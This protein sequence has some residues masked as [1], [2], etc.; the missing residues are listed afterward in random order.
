MSGPPVLILSCHRSGS[1]L[2]RYVLDT[3][4]EIYSP[5]ELFLGN[6]AADLM[7]FLAGLDGEV[8]HSDRLA[9]PRLQAC[10]V[11]A[12][13]LLGERL[14][15]AARRQGKRLWCEKT[16]DN[17]QHLGLLDALFPDTRY[18]CLYRHA[19]DVARSGS[20]MLERIPSLLPYLYASRGHVTTALLRYWT[21]R[22]EALLRFA[23]A[24]PGRVHRVIYED[25]VSDPSATVGPLF[26]FL[27]LDWDPGLIGAVY[28]SSHDPG[29]EDHKARLATGIHQDSVGSGSGLSLAGVPEKVLADLRRVLG[30]LGYPAAPERRPASP[31]RESRAP[32]DTADW[33]IQHLFDSRLRQLFLSLSGAAQSIGT[34]FQ[35][36]VTGEGGGEWGIDFTRGT[37]EIV[38]GTFPAACT[39]C[40]SAPDLKDLVRGR[41]LPQVA[42]S[43]GRIQFAGSFN[44]EALRWLLDA[45]R[46]AV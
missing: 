5:P 17:L 34:S 14:S 25:L 15:A 41:L 1:T 36:V 32:Q 40:L 26:S 46:H 8:F 22:N 28:S 10:L 44:G 11:H 7:Q 30:E 13:Q 38:E 45:L 27:G 35:F 12:R 20:E 29:M 9:E 31:A 21:E 4:P 19:L 18:L 16:P 42:L 37:P 6:L 23:A 24:R 33:S 43:E 2:L 39:I 3:H